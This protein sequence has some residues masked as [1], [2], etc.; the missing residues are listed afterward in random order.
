MKYLAFDLEIA[1][2]ILEGETDW[3]AH[4]PLGITCAE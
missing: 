2:E 4:R 1:R 3:K